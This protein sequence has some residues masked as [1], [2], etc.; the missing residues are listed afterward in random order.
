MHDGFTVSRLSS[1]PQAYA[2]A[3]VPDCGN[4]ARLERSIEVRHIVNLA[5]ECGVAATVPGPD[6]HIAS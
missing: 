5:S 2:F 6:T 4:I 3:A 1:S